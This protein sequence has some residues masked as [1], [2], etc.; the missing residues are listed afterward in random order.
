MQG[1]DPMRRFTTTEGAT[2][3]GTKGAGEQESKG[4]REQGSKGARERGSAGAERRTSS[5]LSL[6]LSLALSVCV[7]TAA[8]AACH[9]VTPTG[10]GA[11]NGSDWNN[12]F[13]GL[14]ATLVRGDSYYIATGTYP[15]YRFNTPESG[16]TVITIK[17][18]APT[19]HCTETGWQ[20]GFG[21]G[22]AVWADNSGAPTWEFS[23][24]G[25][26]IIDGQYRN[27]SKSGHRFR[28]NLATKL[29]GTGNTCFAVNILGDHVPGGLRG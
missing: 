22:Q 20:T 19:D 16:T 25:Y 13:A 17:K 10:S 27:N 9:V 7:G 23:D 26:W 28:I 8:Q 2:E 1:G 21:V 5:F 15:R 29:I 3:Q 14:P 24:N 4:A 11:M 6:T 12:A 18:A